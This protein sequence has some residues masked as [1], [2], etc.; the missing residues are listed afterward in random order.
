MNK[1]LL[2][3]VIRGPHI[4]EK[5]TRIADKSRQITFKVAREAS[6]PQIKRAVELVFSVA[7]DDVAVLNVKGKRR[8]VGAKQ[9]QRK[10]WKKAYVTLAEGHD[11]DFTEF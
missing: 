6:K 4:S 2:F 5:S 1:E 8:R 3:D 7:V 9:G 10:D 11:I